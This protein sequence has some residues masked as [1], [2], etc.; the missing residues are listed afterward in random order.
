[1]IGRGGEQVLGPNHNILIQSDGLVNQ[2]LEVIIN[3]QSGADN[4]Q[5]LN[6]ADEAKPAVVQEELF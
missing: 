2:R 1:L 3:A 4:H 6:R 5:P